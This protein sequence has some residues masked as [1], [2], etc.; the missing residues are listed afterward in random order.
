M[1][2]LREELQALYEAQGE[3]TPVM[4][5]DVARDPAHPLHARFEW[6]DSVAGEKYRRH[7]ARQLIRSVRIRVIDEDDPSLNFDVR[8]Y[9]MVRTSGGGNAYQPTADVVQDPFVSRLILARMQ[10]E[11]QALR[12]R[13]EQFHEFWKLVN[14]DAQERSEGAQ[15]AID[16]YGAYIA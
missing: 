11:W 16:K 14:S 13:Y 3:L 12:E 15:K 1:G 5:V 6:D 10:R 4:V 2:T 9:Q 7:Q 8:A